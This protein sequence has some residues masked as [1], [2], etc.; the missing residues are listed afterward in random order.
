[1]GQSV[2]SLMSF[3][4]NEI[5]LLKSTVLTALEIEVHHVHRQ[6]TQESSNSDQTSEKPDRGGQSL[7]GIHGV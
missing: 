6:V 2:A 3:I 1:M 4:S 7:R 5:M